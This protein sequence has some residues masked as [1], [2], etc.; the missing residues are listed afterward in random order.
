MNREEFEKEVLPVSRKL[1]RFAFRFFSNKEEAEDAV[2]DVFIKL[3]NMRDK[4]SDY[5]NIHAFAM[6]VTRNLCLDRLR[7]K[8]K[9]LIENT[10]V[11]DTRTKEMTPQRRMESMEL[12][13]IVADMIDDLPE[14]YRRVIQMRDIEGCEYNEISEQLGINL[15]NIRVNLSRAR[16]MLRDK[17]KSINYEPA[18][19]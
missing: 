5:N 9:N 10:R 7:K 12:M 3:W 6:T 8:S 2:Q 17:L 19:T 13:K 14:N 16:K 18:G 4:L 11:V 1:Y 15:N